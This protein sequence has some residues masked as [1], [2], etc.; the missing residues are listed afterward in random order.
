MARKPKTPTAPVQATAPRG[1]ARYKI[2]RTE[3]V[4]REE[5]VEVRVRLV[6]TAKFEEMKEHGWSDEDC[7][8]SKKEAETLLAQGQLRMSMT[9]DGLLW[10][11]DGYW[12]QFFSLDWDTAGEWEYN[13][14]EVNVINSQFH[15]NVEVL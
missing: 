13:G 4:V 3:T 5:E 10:L 7:A 11:H 12:S 15:N 9:G 1:P 6:P 14:R 8:R 2:T